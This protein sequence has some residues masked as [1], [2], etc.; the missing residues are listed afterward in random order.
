MPLKGLAKAQNQ[1]TLRT[2]A[3]N[4]M[5]KLGTQLVKLNEATN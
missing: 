3:T 5:T 4:M 2:Q 1:L